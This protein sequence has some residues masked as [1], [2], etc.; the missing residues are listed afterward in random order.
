MPTSSAGQREGALRLLAVLAHPDDESFGTGGT[1]GLYAGRGV[2]VHLICATRG[3]VGEIPEGMLGEDQDVAALREAELRCAASHLGLAGVH[4]LDYRDSGMPGSADNHHPRA[5]AAAPLQEVAAQVLDW[6]K[7]IQPQVV[8]TFDPIGGY[9]HPDHIAIQRA[10][11]Q[12]FHDARKRAPAE[13]F[14]APQKLYFHTFSRLPLRILVRVMRLLGKDPRRWGK[15]GDIDLLEIS[16][17][18]FP[19]HARIDIRPAAKRKARASACHR[20]QS[21]PSSGGW[22]GLLLRL[23]NGSETYIRHF[24]PVEGNVLE[25]DLFAGLGDD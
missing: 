24:P 5:L 12:A 21:G 3:E 22:I 10:A 4:F 25:R 23:F 13:G 19:V 9:R 8:I 11:V 2:Q 15:N 1:L 20:S 6:I 18:D 17:V 14:A 16:S 7:A